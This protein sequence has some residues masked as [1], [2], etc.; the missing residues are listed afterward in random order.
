MKYSVPY[1]ALQTLQALRGV[2][3]SDSGWESEVTARHANSLSL[4]TSAP[5][6]DSVPFRVEGGDGFRIPTS[7]VPHPVTRLH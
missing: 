6:D 2:W 4:A 5:W 3:L 7:Y 1:L